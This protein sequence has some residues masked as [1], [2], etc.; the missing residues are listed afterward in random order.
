MAH[1]VKL[2]DE[3]E[4]K[5]D[6]NKKVKQQEQN[7]EENNE[8]EMQECTICFYDIDTEKSFI[9]CDTCGKQCHAKCYMEWFLQKKEKRGKRKCCIS[10]QQPTLVY[11]E[12]KTSMMSRCYTSIFGGK[13]KIKK[14][15]YTVC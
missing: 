4:K 6:Q 15:Y 8:E 14:K 5:N 7:K 1:F 2:I 3:N 13:P 11:C 10:C 12:A 9:G